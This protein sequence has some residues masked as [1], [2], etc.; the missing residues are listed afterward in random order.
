ME[1][2]NMTMTQTSQQSVIP[3]S[4]FS[5]NELRNINKQDLIKKP[6]MKPKKNPIHM[7]YVDRI[8]D[9]FEKFGFVLKNYSG[10]GGHNNVYQNDNFV[11][12]ITKLSL[13]QE[14]ESKF[15]ENKHLDIGEKYYDEKI[16]LKAVKKNLCPNIYF[17]GNLEAK[18]VVYRYMI[19]EKY[20]YTL[21]SFIQFRQ[22]KTLLEK[23]NYYEDE[24]AIY[25]DIADQI[26]VLLEKTIQNNIVYY[27][28]TPNN[29]VMRLTE[30]GRLQVKLIDWDADLC[31][32]EPWLRD[33]E[34]RDLMNK[35]VLY[36]SVM[37]LDYFVLVYLK[38]QIFKH[39]YQIRY[40]DDV[41]ECLKELL[42]E[43]DSNLFAY[44]L[45]NYFFKELN[46]SLY[47]KDNF[48]ELQYEKRVKIT[49]TGYLTMVD[50]LW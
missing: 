40:R 9:V 45:V 11:L 23:S 34:N 27:D 7:D 3:N 5:T 17:L 28:L 42:M 13:N 18:G 8:E 38:R 6:T 44:M 36:L 1:S 16:F 29:I 33:S 10:K 46:A 43:F 14:D 26:I 39:E 30:E 37:L 4:W 21:K 2:S 49:T 24:E 22:H 25:K 41:W 19:M 31:R 35:T 15:D 48:E 47:E 32:E 50:K 20:T 12:R